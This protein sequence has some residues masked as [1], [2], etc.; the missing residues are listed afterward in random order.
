MAKTLMK[1][2]QMRGDGSS[3]GAEL[4]HIARRQ[5]A[6]YADC[7]PGTS[8]AGEG[9]CLCADEAYWLQIE[10]ARLRVRRGES[11]AGFKI[12]CISQTIRRQLGIEHAVFGHV[13]RSEIRT[14]R[15]VLPIDGFCNLGIEGEFAVTLAEDVLDTERF[16]KAPK[17]YIR[18]VFPVIELHNYVFRGQKPSAAELIANNAFHAGLVVPEAMPPVGP[19]DILNIRVSVDDRIN[20]SASFDPF[21]TLPELADLLACF[22]IGLKAGDILLTGSPLP[23]YPVAPGEC[24]RVACPHVAE[25]M[26]SVD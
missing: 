6:D 11:V 8:F 12:G 5:L 26:A 24:I 16:R 18:E 14:S 17:Q 1:V 25:V 10:T 2:G 13:F 19:S 15:T 21:E 7:S 22:G 4:Q 23:L 20:A 9:L 3:L